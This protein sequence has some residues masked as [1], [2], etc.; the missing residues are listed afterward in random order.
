MNFET[1]NLYLYLSYFFTV[2]WQLTLLQLLIEILQKFL[3]KFEL[4]LLSNYHSLVGYMI[5]KSSIKMIFNRLKIAHL[6]TPSVHN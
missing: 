6:E 3:L 5:I 1:I 4:L 2:I